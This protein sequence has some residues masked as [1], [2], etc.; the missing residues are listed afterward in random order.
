MRARLFETRRMQKEVLIKT[1]NYF[2]IQF[3]KF[4]SSQQMTSK[5]CFV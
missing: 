1:K 2:D 5:K 4:L 3:K